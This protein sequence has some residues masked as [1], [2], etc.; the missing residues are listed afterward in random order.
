MKPSI[1]LE[2]SLDYD[3]DEVCKESS[4]KDEHVYSKITKEDES[5][6]NKDCDLIIVIQ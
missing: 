6:E 2:L 3:W 4:I 5:L 1:E